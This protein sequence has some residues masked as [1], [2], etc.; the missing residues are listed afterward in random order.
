M[1]WHGPVYVQELFTQVDSICGRPRLVCVNWLHPTTNSASVC[2]TMQLCL[3][4]AGSVEQVPA[5]L[6]DSSVTPHTFKRRLKMHLFAAW[7]TPSGAA[8]AFLRVWRRYMRL[9]TYFSGV[10]QQDWRDRVSQTGIAVVTVHWKNFINPSH[11]KHHASAMQVCQYLHIHVP[12]T[13]SARPQIIG[14]EC[15]VRGAGSTKQ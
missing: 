5:T 9:L 10:K 8:A 13:V 7:W 3:Q 1:A 12:I 4:W 14:T 6:P 11:S 2:C 15:I